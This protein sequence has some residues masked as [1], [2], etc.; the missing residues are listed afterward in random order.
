MK[1]VLRFGKKGKHSLQY[2]GLYK[3]SKRIDNVA[4]EFELPQESAAVHPVF[5]FSMLKKCMGDLSLFIPTEDI[6]IKDSLS[7]EEIPVQIL[8]PTVRKLRTKEVASVKVLWRDQFV[9]EVTWEAEEDMKKR[10]RHLFESGEVFERREKR[11]KGEEKFKTLQVLAILVVDFAKDSIL[12]DPQ[13]RLLAYIGYSNE[14]MLREGYRS[15][16][17]EVKVDHV[18]S[19]EK[20]E[21]H[22]GSMQVAGENVATTTQTHIPLNSD[23]CIDPS[24]AGSNY[25]HEEHVESDDPDS[26][27]ET[28]IDETPVLGSGSVSGSEEHVARNLRRRRW[29][30]LLKDY[31]MSVLYHP[32]KANVVADSLSRLSMGSVSHVEKDKKE[33][34]RD[35]RRLARLSVRLFDF[36]KGDVT[37][38]N[39][40]ESSFL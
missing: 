22:V 9:E 17:K 10:Y 13:L 12:R 8:D 27:K 25:Y 24:V 38:H 30:N 23:S 31:D 28:Q 11:R 19:I 36:T 40:L 6:C 37:H 7:Y 1:G 4:Y 34:V 15:W 16:D 5:H 35:V 26:S 3:I 32:N 39:C 29:L 21:V 14:P 18:S 2:S 33:F 20:G